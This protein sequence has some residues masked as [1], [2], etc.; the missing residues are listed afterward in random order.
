MK[1]ALLGKSVA[2]NRIELLT[3]TD[4]GTNHRFRKMGIILLARTH[5]S[6]TASSFTIAG[7]LKFLLSE[8]PAATKLR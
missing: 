7:I 1:R 4:P 5:P 8:S 2:G 3:I 6:E